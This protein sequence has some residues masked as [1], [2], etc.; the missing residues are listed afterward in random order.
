MNVA[1]NSCKDYVGSHPAK[2]LALRGDVSYS[3][4]KCFPLKSVILYMSVTFAYERQQISRTP[5]EGKRLAKSVDTVTLHS[6]NIHYI[7]ALILF[8]LFKPHS[9]LWSIYHPAHANKRE[10]LFQSRGIARSPFAAGLLLQQA[11]RWMTSVLIIWSA[12]CLNRGA[13]SG[14]PGVIVAPIVRTPSVASYRNS[15]HTSL[16]NNNNKNWGGGKGWF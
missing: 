8:D 2:S 16:G 3:S 11:L 5:V 1:W 15:L 12:W 14:T 9:S 4:W 13:T 10:T 6:H 7:S